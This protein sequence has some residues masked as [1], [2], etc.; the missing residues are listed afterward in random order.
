MH[1]W[2]LWS[3]LKSLMWRGQ[4]CGY[5][6]CPQFWSGSRELNG[7]NWNGELLFSWDIFAAWGPNNN[8]SSVRWRLDGNP[9]QINCHG[10]YLDHHHHVQKPAVHF[11]KILNFHKN[12]S[13]FYWISICSTSSWNDDGSARQVTCCSTGAKIVAPLLLLHLRLISLCAAPKLA[14]GEHFPVQSVFI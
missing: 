11:H 13:V 3:A 14:P 4:M 8:Q 12:T 6:K 2:D 1:G 10:S 9:C 7:L 5:S